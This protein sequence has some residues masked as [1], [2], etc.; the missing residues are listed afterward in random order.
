MQ[1]VSVN[2]L[3]S[4]YREIVFGVPQGS[5]LGPLPF[6]IYVNDMERA[7]GCKLFLYAYDSALLVS[8]RSVQEIEP[9]LSRELE[10]IR[11]RLTDNKRSLHLGKADSVLFESPKRFNKRSVMKISCGDTSVTAKSTVGYLGSKLRQTL[12]GQERFNS[13]ITK[14]NSR[15]IF[16]Y[17]QARTLGTQTISGPSSLLISSF[18]LLTH[19]LFL[20]YYGLSR[21]NRTRLQTCQNKLIRFVL[22]L[23]PRTHP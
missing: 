2:S 15:L 13:I 9:S 21:R 7:V 12:D 18:I 23:G 10:S 4:T 20:V 11:I 5:T 19:T 16:L 6:L 22:G 17:W 1:C 3:L 14:T 8:G